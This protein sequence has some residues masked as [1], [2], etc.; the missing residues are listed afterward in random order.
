MEA[1]GHLGQRIRRLRKQ[2]GFS[3]EQLA[4][5]AGT[6][7]KYLSRIELGRENPTFDLLL[8]LARS[9]GIELSQLLELEPSQASEGSAQ[10]GPAGVRQEQLSL[11]MAL[12]PQSPSF[13]SLFGARVRQLRQSRDWSQE[14]LA[15]KTHRHRTYIASI[16]RGERNITLRVVEALA[17]A[18]DVP[19]PTLFTW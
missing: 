19:V 11:A 14:T 5:R 17:Q 2:H 1:K 18:L 8:G 9:V 3:Q 10:G 15:E 13:L 12:R 7:A 16:E 4:E 6:S